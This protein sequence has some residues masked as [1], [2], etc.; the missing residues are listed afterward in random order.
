[1]PPSTLPTSDKG[2]KSSL[3]AGRLAGSGRDYHSTVRWGAL[4]CSPPGNFCAGSSKVPLPFP[5]ALVI[6]RHR[7]LS[8]FLSH[9]VLGTV[10]F[11]MSLS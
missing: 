7:L 6:V 2:E 5:T 4:A 3:D 9:L 1:M 10:G 8:S 11:F